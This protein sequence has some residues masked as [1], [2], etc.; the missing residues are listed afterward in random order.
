M[1]TI[2]GGSYINA[3]WVR[4]APGT[5]K[6][7][8]QPFIMAQAPTMETMGDFY[9]LLYQHRVSVIVCLTP[10]VECGR[11]KANR[12]WPSNKGESVSVAS[13][14]MKLEDDE[15]FCRGSIVRRTLRLSLRDNNRSADFGSLSASSDNEEPEDL[16]LTMLHYTAWS[17]QASPAC[18]DSFSE[19]IRQ[20]RSVADVDRSRPVVAHCS[21]GVGRAGTFVASY[22]LILLSE[23]FADRLADSS[24]SQASSSST[25]TT[26]ISVLTSSASDS[27]M[28]VVEL[29]SRASAQVSESSRKVTVK[30]MVDWL[31]NQRYG[32]VQTVSQY[33]FIPKVVALFEEAA[34]SSDSLSLSTSSDDSN[35]EE[36]CWLRTCQF[37]S[38]LRVR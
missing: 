4:D 1:V 13:Y 9:S 23:L 35:E 14:I 29:D 24:S 19:L 12:Y 16:V 32:A 18:L 6:F 3:N 7:A 37:G 31:R 8:P 30:E 27:A 20:V 15:S 25:T 2:S 36:E 38:G 26:S 22:N 33:K 28:A 21:A 5:I 10:L 34:S 17:D 11:V